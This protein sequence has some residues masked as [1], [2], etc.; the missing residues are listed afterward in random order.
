MD[1]LSQTTAWFMTH[2]IRK[3][4][5]QEGGLFAGPERLTASVKEYVDGMAHTDGIESFS[6]TL[7]PWLSL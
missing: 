1:L 5:D 4:L 2:R 6:A 7:K 3:A